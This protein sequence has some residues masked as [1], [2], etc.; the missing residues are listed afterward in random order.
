MKERILRLLNLKKSESAHVLD[1]LTVQFFIGIASSLINFL[2]I[3]HFIDK[4]TVGEI[5]AVYLVIAFA[6]LI[7]NVVYEKLEHNL[8]ATQ[9]LKII[10]LFNAGVL[11][12]IWL[13]FFSIEEHAVSFVL[14]VWTV[15]IYMISSYAFW[16]MASQQYNIRESKRI[17][18]IL[19]SADIMSKLVGYLIAKPVY[20]LVGDNLMLVAIVSLVVGAIWFTGITKSPR[21]QHFAGRNH[22]HQTETVVANTSKDLIS[23]VFKKE[24]IFA[25]SLLSLISYNVFNLVDFTFVS[26]IKAHYNDFASLGTFVVALL[27]SGR[28][29]A[30]ILKLVFSS[31]MIE[32]LGVITSLFITPVTLLFFCLLFLF[33]DEKNTEFTLYIFG[34]MTILTEVLRSTMQE[35]VFF[36]LF[37]PLKEKFR[38]KGHLIS[39]GYMLAPSLLIVG[40]SLLFIMN[41]YQGTDISIMLIIKLLLVNL[42]LWGVI[43]FFL[44]N[45][46]LKTLRDS[47]KKGVFAAENNAHIKDPGSIGILLEKINSG[48]P[49]EIIYALKLLEDGE[50]PALKKLM[51]KLIRHESMEVRYYVVENL[52]SRANPPLDLLHQILLEEKH[53]AIVQKLYSVLTRKDSHFLKKAAETLHQQSYPVQKVIVTSLLNQ[54]EFEFLHQGGNYL[55]ALIH[56]ADAQERELAVQVIM[57]L[58]NVRFTEAIEQLIHDAEPSV[59]RSAILA[60]CRLKI[61]QLLPVIVEMLQNPPAKYAALNGLLQYGD[62]LF[63]HIHQLPQQLQNSFAYEAIKL[64]GKMKGHHSTSYLL[65]MLRS[66]SKFSEHIIHSLW[67]K[68]FTAE[69]TKDVELLQEFLQDYLQAGKQKIADYVQVPVFNHGEQMKD[70]IV[71]EIKNDLTT[72]LKICSLLHNNDELNRILELIQHGENL[73]LYNAIEM[74]DLILPKKVSRDLNLLFNYLFDPSLARR[75]GGGMAV[76]QF[77][78]KIVIEE[79]SIFRPLTRAYCIYA[80]WKDHE[81]GFLQLLKKQ[82]LNDEHFIIGETSQFVLKELESESHADHRKNITS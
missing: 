72:S 11:F 53:P 80:S 30:L 55:D 13:G 44:R 62:D 68:D 77:F 59:K 45:A 25:I 40:V 74:L 75:Q 16:G 52:G 26:Q 23:T 60:A 47:I 71:A 42:L 29:I 64:A 73:R 66:K 76:S 36:I 27:A 28:I 8:T 18:T 17:F 78:N 38:L 34:F 43:I 7:I 22:H 51:E 33:V 3:T 9:L 82:N 4:Q 69:D 63:Q 81:T 46:Y 6:L 21:W 67:S 19:G 20:G 12:F 5:P 39:K 1:L 70:V 10:M 32:R 37:Q 14:L 79:G 41:K 57:E 48:K 49:T 61:K 2:G 15:L 65:H 35:P 56:S 54:K 58:K 24:L 50:Y 31:R